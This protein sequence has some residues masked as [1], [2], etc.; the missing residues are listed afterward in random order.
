[1]I[2]LK[3]EVEERLIGYCFVWPNLIGKFCSM[4]RHEDFSVHAPFAKA[5]IELHQHGKPVDYITV[6]QQIAGDDFEKFKGDSIRLQAFSDAIT[7]PLDFQKWVLLFYE[8]V[9]REEMRML[10]LDMQSEEW[11]DVLDSWHL[12][13]DKKIELLKRLRS[14]GYKPTEILEELAQSETMITYGL[15]L[16]LNVSLTDLVIVAAR[17]SMGK[18]AFAVRCALNLAQTGWPVAFMSR[19]MSTKQIGARVLSILARIPASRILTNNIFESE[20]EAYDN[21]QK[22][23]AALPFFIVDPPMEGVAAIA[24]CHEMIASEGVRAVFVDYLQQFEGEGN[25]NSNR[26][27][28]IA[29]LSRNFKALAKDT[30]V[31]VMLLSQL[32]RET[33]K[34]KE[35]MP[36][37]SDLRESGAIEQDADVVIMLYRPEYYSEETDDVV[38]VSGTDYPKQGLA[39]V[40]VE[41]YRNGK[42]GRRVMKFVGEFMDFQNYEIEPRKVRTP[43][44]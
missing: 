12:L 11:S 34:R 7:T 44:D 39:I 36:V 13:D 19:E 5:I 1:M 14:K 43:F 25:K 16:D 6:A 40:G 4:L 29:W 9:L 21:A 31:P 24:K 8:E 35:K 10:G 38:S 37:L 20:L 28:R 18:T 22:H 26:E 41:K 33:E 23:F 42:T 2:P 15:D 32:S 3:R 17:P 27:N 30:G